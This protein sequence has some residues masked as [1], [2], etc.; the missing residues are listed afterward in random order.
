M[1]PHELAHFLHPHAYTNDTYSSRFVQKRDFK[2]KKVPFVDFSFDPKAVDAKRDTPI[3]Y[4]RQT[5]M[6]YTSDNLIAS[7]RDNHNPF[8]NV[9]V[10]T[11]VIFAFGFIGYFGLWRRRLGYEKVETRPW[12]WAESWRERSTGNLHERAR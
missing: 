6:L 11:L 2:D 10:V 7:T 12:V 8:W 9:F 4:Y 1:V 3:S 5:E